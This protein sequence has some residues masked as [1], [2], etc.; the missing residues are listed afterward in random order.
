MAASIIESVR[1]LIT[2]NV[3]TTIAGRLGENPQ[4]VSRG[5]TAG[6]TSILAGLAN[7]TSDAGAMSRVFDLIAKP[8]AG[9]GALADDVSL[10]REGKAP[11]EL[12]NMSSRFLADLFGDR[13]PLIN[14]VV[15]EASGLSGESASSIM[16]FAAPIVLGFLGR[17]VRSG[18]LD[19]AS[20][21]QLFSI[22]KNNIMRAAPPGIAAALG[23][24][25][26][27]ADAARERE[28]AFEREE[29]SRRE[30]AHQ[31]YE[32]ERAPIEPP[33]EGSSVKW[34]WPALATLAVLALIWGARRAHR[35]SPVD[36]TSIAGGE[37]AAPVTPSPMPSTQPGSLSLPN[38]TT[39][40]VP[41]GGVES[42]FIG[43]IS[44]STRQPSE[45]SYFDFDRLMFATNSPALLPQSDEQVS[46]IAKILTA[47]PGVSVKIAGYTDNVG[48]P[49]ANQRLSA[50]RAA[51]VKAALIKNGIAASRV[52]SEGYGE[53]HPEADNSTDAGRAQNRRVALIVVRK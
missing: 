49:S 34:M 33:H 6:A 25:S 30:S 12:S 50:Q 24:E 40:V 5:L 20:F 41:A 23:A 26:P 46:N 28:V 47:Y 37:V 45:S 22:E 44:D 8:G 10:M 19:L 32:R 39:L 14:G 38:G 21:T 29:E 51:N 48:N 18:G 2:D 31:A 15:G 1:Q 4:N 53:K 17:H 52:T 43:F 9:V 27:R 16:R 11:T 42:R 35:P 13:A 36:T 3:V 7:K